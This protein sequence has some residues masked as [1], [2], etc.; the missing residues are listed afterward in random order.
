AT[1]ENITML[2]GKR[3]ELE[4]AAGEKLATAT[5]QGEKLAGLMVQI[6]QKAGVDGRLFGSVTNGDIAE[7]LKAQSFEV[8]KGQIHMPAGPLKTVG[9]HHVTVQLHTD[10]KVE[11]TISVLGDH[12]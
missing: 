6:T 5:A 4:R 1:A 3:A 9:D 8:E 10:V 2:E 11:I 12:S 7:A